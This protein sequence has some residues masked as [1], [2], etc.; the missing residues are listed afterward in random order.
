MSAETEEQKI[1]PSRTGRRSE[2][3]RGLTLSHYQIPDVLQMYWHVAMLS[4]L[5]LGVSGDVG[6]R[7]AFLSGGCR[8]LTKEDCTKGHLHDTKYYSPGKKKHIIIL[9]LITKLAKM[10]KR[11][12]IQLLAVPL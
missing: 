5:A 12:V 9:L 1:N 2:G 10:K 8:A 3:A 4:G 6:Q 11:I 7:G